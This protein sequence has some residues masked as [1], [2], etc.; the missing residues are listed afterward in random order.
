MTRPAWSA[1]A[2]DRLV[3]CSERSMHSGRAMQRRGAQA[4]RL[5]ASSGK[6]SVHSDRRILTGA[7]GFINSA[8]RSAL[9]ARE[10]TPRGG[11]SSLVGDHRDTQSIL[12]VMPGLRDHAPRFLWS[13]TL[14]KPNIAHM[15]Q[16]PR[17]R[18][19][20]LKGPIRQSADKVFTTSSHRPR[21]RSLRAELAR[22]FIAGR[23]AHRPCRTFRSHRAHPLPHGHRQRPFPPRS[24]HSL[25]VRLPVFHLPH[26]PSAAGTRPR[27]TPCSNFPTLPLVAVH[28]PW[29]E[30]RNRS[31]RR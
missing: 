10:F 2:A 12:L 24:C 21:A 14:V 25:P 7:K 13:E 22:E 9:P 19:E 18:R 30:P 16:E 31:A 28:S 5:K 4:L 11:S 20:G 6:Q 1:C 29:H 27:T 17:S 26:L 15:V 23:P 8:V 3:A